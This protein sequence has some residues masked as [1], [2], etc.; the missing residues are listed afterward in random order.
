MICQKTGCV[1]YLFEYQHWV[2]GDSFLTSDGSLVI[3]VSSRHHASPGPVNYEIHHVD[4][5]FDNVDG[6]SAPSTLIAG[7]KDYRY[8]GYDGRDL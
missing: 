8:F 1:A 7:S 3:R 4:H 6:R 2:R 5:W